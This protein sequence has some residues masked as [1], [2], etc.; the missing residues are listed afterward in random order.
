MINLA[1]FTEKI[2]EDKKNAFLSERKDQ[3]S[4]PVCVLAAVSC[5]LGGEALHYM[6]DSGTGLHCVHYNL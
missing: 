2:P 4:G 1:C 3:L 5:R 6:Y